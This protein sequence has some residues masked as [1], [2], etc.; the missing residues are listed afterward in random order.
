MSFAVVV[1]SAFRV[2]H[3]ALEKGLAVLLFVI[4][5]AAKDLA[6][7]HWW[8]VGA[9]RRPVWARLWRGKPGTVMG[10]PGTRRVQTAWEAM[11]W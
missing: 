6:G 10:V 9:Q 11:L 2:P 3:S 7:C 8:L 5:S 1:H 4:L